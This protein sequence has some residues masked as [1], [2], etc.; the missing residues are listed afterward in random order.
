MGCRAV[1]PGRVGVWC[2]G[3]W[4]PRHLRVDEVAAV[5]KAEEVYDRLLRDRPGNM[6]VGTDGELSWRVAGRPLKLRWV[7]RSNRIWRGGR[8][9]LLCPVCGRTKSRGYRGP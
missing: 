2:C 3:R 5:A 8:G 6:C 1:I 4:G 7:L 9:F